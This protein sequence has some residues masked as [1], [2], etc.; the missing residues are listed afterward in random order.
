MTDSPSL[1]LVKKEREELLVVREEE[2]FVIRE[3]GAPP[4]RGACT[5]ASVLPA[6]TFRKAVCISEVVGLPSTRSTLVG[7]SIEACSTVGAAC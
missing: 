5:I 7:S 3:S 2:L 6:V 1:P 4:S